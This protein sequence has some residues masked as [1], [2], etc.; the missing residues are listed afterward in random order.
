M[1]R[2]R[3]RDDGWIRNWKINTNRVLL[4]HGHYI[5]VP[6]YSTLSSAEKVGMWDYNPSLKLSKLPKKAK[7]ALKRVLGVDLLDE[8]HSSKKG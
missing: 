8:A 5:P 3:A 1:R 4:E 7:A 2:N 6:F